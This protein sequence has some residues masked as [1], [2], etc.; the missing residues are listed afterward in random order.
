[1]ETTKLSSKG[2]VI[3]PKSVREAHGWQAGV[4]FSVEPAGEGVLLRPLKPFAATQ[5]KDVIGCAGYQG[6]RKSLD[7]MERAIEKGVRTRR[8]GGRY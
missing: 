4:E 3:L 8:A 1:M 2:Q 5:L 6:S 7:E